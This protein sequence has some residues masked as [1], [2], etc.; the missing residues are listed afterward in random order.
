LKLDKKVNFPMLRKSR[1]VKILDFLISKLNKIRFNL[2]RKIA[3]KEKE[4]P[5]P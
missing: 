4:F 3:K 5:T 2:I 1:R